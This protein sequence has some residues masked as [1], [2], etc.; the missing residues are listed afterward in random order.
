M[1]TIL[2]KNAQTVITNDDTL[3]QIPGGWVLIRDDV[4][5][6]IGR[7]ADPLPGEADTVI[8]AA[9]MAVMPGLI[10][11]HHHFYQ[12][13]TR[14]VPGAQD[15]ELF[16]WLVRLYPIWG[17]MDADAVYTSTL[18]AMAELILSGCTTSSDHLYLIPNGSSFD[19][20][21]R[22]AQKI[23][24]RFHLTRGSMSLGRSRGGLPPDH[25]VQEED[26]I[27]KD[28]QRVIETYHNPKP[29][30]ML[31][32]ALAPCSPF[33]VTQDLLRQAA[34]LARS[35][36]NVML[37]T[38]VAET[39]DEETFCVQN[40]GMRPAPLMQSLGWTGPDVWWAHS[41]FV[42]SEEIR[43]M[44]ETGTGVAHCPSSN[45]RLGSGIC[46]VR[47]MIDAGVKVGLGVDGSASNDSSHLFTEARNAL[48]LQRVNG[49]AA[50]FS[51]EEAFRLATRG[52]AQ[53]LGRNELGVLAPG[54]AADVI[55]V[56]LD[57]LS[58]AGGAVHDP[59]GALLLCTVQGVDFSVIN[60][61][62]V[63]HKGKLL[64]LDLEELIGQHNRIARKIVQKYPVPERF[65]LV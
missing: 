8:D 28:C 5:E 45:M 44:A 55:G 13:L 43:M 12:T 50:A 26:A 63:V 34:R 40:F 27:L 11:T 48:L 41:I 10:N 23:G 20:Q 35:Y 1:S 59:L 33:S 30:A 25:V 62:V 32:V 29:N 53:V 49:G 15:Q 47:E 31:R 58:M 61:Q 51:V 18:T 7:P 22:A 19:D 42:N 3:G 60:G 17:E 37:H 64:T 38:H 21:V 57:T 65:K 54:K 6:Q 56:R 46:P 39:R 36:E 2:I 4:I 24:I 16:D 14:A 52:S 9:N